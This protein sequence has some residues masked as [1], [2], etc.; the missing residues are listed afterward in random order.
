MASFEAAIVDALLALLTGLKA[1]EHTVQRTYRARK[2]FYTFG[3]VSV[4]SL[5]CACL[6][7][8]D[9]TPATLVTP[10]CFFIFCV[11]MRPIIFGDKHIL[12]KLGL[13]K[14]GTV[15]LDIKQRMA[16]AKKRWSGKTPAD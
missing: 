8:L 16:K 4:V 12:E 1:A 11:I 2:W 7:A 10:I 3:A 15:D 5:L 14:K 9:T 6:S 13:K